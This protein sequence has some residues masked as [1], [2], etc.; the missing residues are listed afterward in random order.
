MADRQAERM[1]MLE[2]KYA[3]LKEQ[4]AEV[5]DALV[6]AGM[7]GNVECEAQT[8]AEAIEML[9]ERA[10]LAKAEGTEASNG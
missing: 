1:L 5:E 4:L 6:E 10:A 8:Y 3:E 7:W 2:V 9:A